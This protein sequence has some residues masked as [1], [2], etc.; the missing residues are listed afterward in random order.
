MSE[1]PIRIPGPDHPITVERNPARVVVKLGDRIVADT[2]HALT[3][4][5]ASYPPVQYIPRRD[6]D[7]SLLARTDHGTYCPYKGD[8]SYFSVTP[9]GERSKNAVWTYENPHEA[10]CEIKDHLAFYPDRVDSIE[11]V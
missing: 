2:R 8:A 4:R 10:V 1:K 6:V 9:G 3:L 11:E 7:M 5:E